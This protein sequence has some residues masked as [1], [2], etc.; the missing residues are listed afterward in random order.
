M[1]NASITW[2]TPGGEKICSRVIHFRLRGATEGDLLD[3]QD[4]DLI[5]GDFNTIWPMRRIIVWSGRWMEDWQSGFMHRWK[6]WWWCLSSLVGQRMSTAIFLSCLYLRHYCVTPVGRHEWPD[7]C[8]KELI[9]G[10]LGP[11]HQPVFHPGARCTHWDYADVHFSTCKIIAY[12]PG[13]SLQ[14]YSSD[15][16]ANTWC[17][18][19]LKS[20]LASA[21]THFPSCFIASDKTALSKLS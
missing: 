1:Q 11:F 14:T 13:L 4:N 3:W 16:W 7:G 15:T 19:T 12:L 5:G 10:S 21:K 6:Y 17:D 18:I 20:M 8:A 2:S 9:G